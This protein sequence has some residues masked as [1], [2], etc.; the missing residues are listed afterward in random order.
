MLCWVL[1]QRQ[2]NMEWFVRW[3]AGFESM[4]VALGYERCSSDYN[5]SMYPALFLQRTQHTRYT[6]AI[7]HRDSLWVQIKS[8]CYCWLLLLQFS[9]LGSRCSREWSCNE[10]RRRI[11]TEK[12]KK[13]KMNDRS[14]RN[15]LLW[16]GDGEDE[17]KHSLIHQIIKTWDEHEMIFNWNC[18]CVRMWAHP[19]AQH[20]TSVDDWRGE[21]QNLM[22]MMMPVHNGIR[23]SRTHNF[24]LLNEIM[25]DSVLPRTMTTI[26][27]Q[28]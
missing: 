15:G 18:P 11:A 17:W 22:M 25:T 19:L 24:K 27:E 8:T 1:W 2:S 10:A 7:N 21:L 13:E 16:R 28:K 5:Y 6:S 23:P 26:R 20:L 9:D 14:A 3:L 12:E 4:C